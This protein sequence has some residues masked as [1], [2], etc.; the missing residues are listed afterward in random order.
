[1]A[2]DNSATKLAANQLLLE[3]Y[4][5]ILVIKIMRIPPVE[6]LQ[7]FTKKIQTD[8]GYNTLVLPGE[9]DTSVEILSVCDVEVTDLEKLQKMVYDN[10]KLL[11][12]DG[13]E[14]VTFKTAK[15]IGDEK[16]D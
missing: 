4:E 7:A 10:I 2:K 1:M 13:A 15:E 6:E 8:F 3:K 12:E 11:E 9:L 14:E 5:P 16:K